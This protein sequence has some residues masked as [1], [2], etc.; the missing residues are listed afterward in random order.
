ML[1]LLRVLIR[2]TGLPAKRNATKLN[3][4]KSMLDIA[5]HDEHSINLVFCLYRVLLINNSTTVRT[6]YTN[7]VGG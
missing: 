2:F 1:N 6:C 7:I 3:V 4:H 5:L